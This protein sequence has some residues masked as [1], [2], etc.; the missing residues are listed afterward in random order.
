MPLLYTPSLQSL[1]PP[2]ALA[3]LTN[4]KTKLA[5]D[6]AAV[7]KAFPDLQYKTYLHNWLI[8][9]TRTFYFVSP[10]TKPKNVPKNR[11]DCMALNPF[12]D[13][14]NHTSPNAPTCCNV[15]ST[16]TSPLSPLTPIS[17]K[18]DIYHKLTHSQVA[19]TAAG[20]TITTRP[21]PTPTIPAGS[22]IHISYGNH[23]NDFLL[24]EYG[25]IMSENEHDLISLDDL[26]LP[27]FSASQK[28]PLEEKGFLGNYVLDQ[29]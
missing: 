2:A 11:D 12:A 10:K 5:T 4:Q 9:N 25:F 15:C 8:V 24:A 29:E 27:L 22:E 7:S 28:A 13:Y 6:W 3:L 20:Y 16:S 19:F 1:L 18:Q 14:F 17:L 23:S 26:L 21:H